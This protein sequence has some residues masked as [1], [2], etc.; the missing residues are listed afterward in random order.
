M[1]F[2]LV[3]ALRADRLGAYGHSG[4]LTPTMDALAAEGVT[5]EC[6]VSAAPW[7]LPSVATLFTSVY[8]GVHL[9]KSYR[10]VA[11]MED[12]KQA[13][14]SVLPESFETMAEVFQKN[15]YQTAG[16]V[17][18][19]FLRSGYGFG[20]GFETYDTS[21][22]DNT[23]RGEVV[24]NALF[25]WLDAE[26]DPEKPLF[27]YLHYMDV[28][29][30]YN[31][32][33]RFLDPLMEQVEAKEDKQLLTAQQFKA[34]R[35]YLRKPPAESSDP[36][37]YD[38]LKAYREYWVARYEG[39][40]AE[41][42]FYLRQLTRGLAERGIWESACVIL[43]ADHGEALCEHD[44]WGHGYSL[45][46][47]DLHVPLIMR[48]PNVTPPQLGV[49]RL[50]SLID[51]MPTVVDQFGLEG[52]PQMQGRSL[53]DHMSGRLSK[54]P[55]SRLAEAVKTEWVDRP[56]I[57]HLALY[58]ENTKFMV[59]N[60]P[61]QTRPDGSTAPPRGKYELYD[62]VQDAGEQ[63]NLAQ[64]YP[65]YLKQMGQTLALAVAKNHELRQQVG[66]AQ[67]RSVDDESMRDLRSLGYAGGEEEE[68]NGP[69]EKAP[70]TQPVSESAPAYKPE[71]QP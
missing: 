6:C 7:T 4:K 65:D 52:A 44:I 45:Y 31:A 10:V 37:R 43:T 28:H 35:H 2:I 19:K 29:G 41:M 32:A 13:E 33:P 40:V 53:V 57:L 42:D 62:L 68:P 25:A 23:V 58:A 64:Q 61:A 38:R 36:T 59:T 20:Q 48:W 54:V 11:D 22:A 12:G 16:F 39:G 9:A 14:Q 66:E 17:A 34:I 5:F 55:Q 71:D 46:Q 30:P 24:N 3:D 1:V 26:R 15:G 70:A 8:P 27:L 56:T 18:A 69:G 63:K 50:A 49:R 21:F 67:R 47:T 51:V 60:F